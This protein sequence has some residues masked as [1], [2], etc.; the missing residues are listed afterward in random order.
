[1]SLS[2]CITCCDL[3]FHLLDGLLDEFQK[4]TVAP[5]EIII[6]SSGISDESLDKYK[7][8]KIN[9]EIV[10]IKITNNRQRHF[11]SV[12][13][14][15]GAANSAFEYIMFFDVDDFPHPKKIEL[16]M[17]NVKGLD[18]L[19]HNYFPSPEHNS[20]SYSAIPSLS[21]LLIDS[22]CTNLRV[23]PDHAI[24]HSH[25]TVKKSIFNSIKYNESIDFYRKEDGKFCQDLVNSGY[26]GKYL[27]LPLVNYTS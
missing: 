14:N 22:S 27:N 25:I 1:M 9:Q 18:F 5:N 3:D 2:L 19:L 11:Q 16:C 8:L 7:D 13:R 24:H 20:F 10:D 4:Q 6:S 21:D 26:K 23:I 12:A 15:L 17:E